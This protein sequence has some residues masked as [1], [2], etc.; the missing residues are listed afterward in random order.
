MEKIDFTDVFA[1]DYGNCKRWKCGWIWI[2]KHARIWWKRWLKDRR[3]MDIEDIPA[4]ASNDDKTAN[5][6]HWN[7][8]AHTQNCCCGLYSVHI[9]S[10]LYTF[11]VLNY[12]NISISRS[13]SRLSVSLRLSFSHAHRRANRQQ[14]ACFTNVQIDM[15][16]H[17]NT[18]RHKKREKK[19]K[20]PWMAKTMHRIVKVHTV[21]PYESVITYC[22]EIILHILFCIFFYYLFVPAF[23]WMCRCGW[24]YS[25]S[26]SLV[27]LLSLFHTITV[28]ATKA[29]RKRYRFLRFSV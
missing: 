9:I 14:W 16:S 18:R 19:K 10:V 25:P 11:L 5:R 2:K 26:L 7:M 21:M 24:W 4:W 22:R 8:Y 23:S 1:Y 3:R 17:T 20:N 28:Y 27:A 15:H 29:K 13:L 12:A 6:M